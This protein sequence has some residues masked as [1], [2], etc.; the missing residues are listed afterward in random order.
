MAERIGIVGVGL[1]GASIGLA[2]RANRTVKEIVGI[3]RSQDSLLLAK[4]RGAIDHAVT[5][6]NAAA[7]L[8]RSLDFLVICTPVDAVVRA[9]CTLWPLLHPGCIVTDAG[10]TKQTIVEQIA[11][12]LPAMSRFI[13]SHPIAGSERTGPA[14]AS[15]S[16]FR[17]RTAVVTPVH[18]SEQATVDAVRAFWLS[19]GMTVVEMPPAEHD[20]IL[21]RTSHLPHLIA[22]ALSLVTDIEDRPFAGT[23][24][25][26]TTRIASGDP[27]LWRAIFAENRE[28]VLAALDRF[29]GA[30]A[31]L[32]ACLLER[33]WPLLEKRLTDGKQNRDALGRQHFGP[34]GTTGP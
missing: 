1:I 24:L 23:G 30:L 14:A 25:R 2:L 11:L 5:D 7:D 12:Q 31:G 32:R 17:G 28:A 26:D 33:D 10:S 13:G 6:L 20:A 27:A 16:L 19:L 8:L 3:G 22:S 4:E 9:A 18:G 15:A 34:G 29:E 21:A